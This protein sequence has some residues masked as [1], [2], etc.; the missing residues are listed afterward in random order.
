MSHWL[1]QEP[2]NKRRS[3]WL[4]GSRFVS[5]YDRIPILSRVTKWLN[6]YTCYT[7]YRAAICKHLVASIKE[8]RFHGQ[9][10]NVIPEYTLKSAAPSLIYGLLIIA[11]IG[12]NLQKDCFNNYLLY[13]QCFQLLIIS[14]PPP[15][16]PPHTHTHTL[17][18]CYCQAWSLSDVAGHSKTT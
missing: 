14:L 2:I 7:Q 3:G 11:T 10:R 8:V 16:P 4:R 12:L 6:P 18:T 15:L 9:L 17:R 13:I 5:G 1:Y